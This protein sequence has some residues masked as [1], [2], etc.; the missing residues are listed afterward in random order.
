[1]VR[2]PTFFNSFFRARL[3]AFMRSIT[4]GDSEVVGVSIFFPSALRRAAAA[5]VFA[6]A[7]INTPRPLISAQRLMISE[8][9]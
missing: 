6:L 4:F 7:E 2:D 8:S 5:S 3:S 9:G 1:M